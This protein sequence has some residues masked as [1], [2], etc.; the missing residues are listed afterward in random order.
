MKERRKEGR[1]E[2]INVDEE[3][4]ERE[5]EGEGGAEKHSQCAVY[6]VPEKKY[7]GCYNSRTL[8]SRS[9][10]SLRRCVYVCCSLD[11]AVWPCSST[12]KLQIGSNPTK[13]NQSLEEERKG[14]AKNVK[15]SCQK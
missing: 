12:G 11:L 3:Q 9:K 14:G 10:Y 4:R 6:N 8:H 5:I 1:Q 13:I 2:H 7:Y 15:S